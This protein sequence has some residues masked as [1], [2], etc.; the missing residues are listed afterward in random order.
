[1]SANLD[2][3]IQIGHDV[4][5]VKYHSLAVGVVL[6]YDYF[7]TLADEIKYVWSEKRSWVFWLYVFIRYFP[8]TWQFWQLGMA[9]APQFDHGV[10]EKTAWYPV[11]GFIFCTFLAQVMLILRTY[12]VMMKNL[13]ITIGF[14][15]F[16]ASQFVFGLWGT[17][18]AA[19]LGARTLPPIPLDAYHLC[20]FVLH[21]SVEVIYASL[22]LFFDCLAFLLTIRWA[23][24]SKA[25]SGG[26]FTTVLD[27]IKEGATWYFLLIFSSHFALVMTL[28]FG[29][30]PIQLLPASGIVVYLSVMVSRTMLSLRKAA[31]SRLEDSQTPVE[32][33]ASTPSLQGVELSRL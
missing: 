24:K 5:S 21:R 22:S 14:T 16:A 10:C 28:S 3:I 29:R 8:M 2:S 30:Q 25:L 9:Y 6:F 15:I 13:P 11:F 1:M 33:P 26:N 23:R 12:A 7:L 19:K 20:V 18:Q 32:P 4:T 17:V 27:S 31:D